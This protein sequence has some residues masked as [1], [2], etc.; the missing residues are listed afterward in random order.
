MSG[1]FQIVVSPFANIKSS[2][3]NEK[4]NIGNTCYII[5]VICCENIY[6][7]ITNRKESALLAKNLVLEIELT[8]ID[9]K[10]PN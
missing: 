1:C 9:K 4:Y 10:F 7:Y 6:L 5:P 2:L 8:K 3:K